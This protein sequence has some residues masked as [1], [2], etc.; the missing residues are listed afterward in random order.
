V[1]SAFRPGKLSRTLR[2]PA[3]T[4]RVK[5]DVNQVRREECDHF[6]RRK[7]HNRNRIERFGV[8]VERGHQPPA[9]LTVCTRHNKDIFFRLNGLMR[10]RI[11]ER[12]DRE[13]RQDKKSVGQ[14]K[15]HIATRSRCGVK[16]LISGD[17]EGL[18]RA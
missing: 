9:G 13:E 2:A 11:T 17:P 14:S 16:L 15:F 4:L 5:I 8:G 6:F 10:W 18:M 12:N 1:C 7:V 3:P